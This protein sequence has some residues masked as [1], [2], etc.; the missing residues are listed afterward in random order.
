M[1]HAMQ[2]RIAVMELPPVSLAMELD[3]VITAVTI[4]GTVIMVSGRA[5]D[6]FTSCRQNLKWALEN[7]KVITPS[8]EQVQFSKLVYS[9][10]R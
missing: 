5:P 1:V 6:L 7:M 8:E 9:F 4:S 10:A 3:C 2:Y